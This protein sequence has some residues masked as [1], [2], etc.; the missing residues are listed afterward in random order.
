MASFRYDRTKDAS[1]DKSK[2]AEI[3]RELGLM[4]SRVAGPAYQ[5]LSKAMHEFGIDKYEIG[6]GNIG[7]DSEGNF[8][9]IDSSIFPPDYGEDDDY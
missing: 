8:K 7:Q 9:I 3:A 6:R 5:E 1:A 4:L 2:S